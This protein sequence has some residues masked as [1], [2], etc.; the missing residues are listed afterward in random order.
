MTT[1]QIVSIIVIAVIYLFPIVIGWI[2]LK[3]FRNKCLLTFIDFFFGWTV[4][5]WLYALWMA[6]R[7]EK[8]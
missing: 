3:N 4:I 6:M 5:G 7:K 8:D 2:R 1:S